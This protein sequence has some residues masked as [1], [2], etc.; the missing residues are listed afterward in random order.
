MNKEYTPLRRFYA[1]V[2]FIAIL[3][4]IALGLLYLAS[5]PF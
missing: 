3:S 5:L 4:I 1:I 2:G